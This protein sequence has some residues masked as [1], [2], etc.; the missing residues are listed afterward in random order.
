MAMTEEMRDLISE[1]D[2]GE[3]RQTILKF[4][5]LNRY[6]G[7]RDGEEAVDY[8]MRKLHS[9]GIP[10]HKEEFEVLRS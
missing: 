3:L 4:S 10:C 1:I 8:L 5:R 7:S 9:Y 2:D 6:T